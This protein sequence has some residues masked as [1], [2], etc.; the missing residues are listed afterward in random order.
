[1]TTPLRILAHDSGDG[2]IIRHCPFCGGGQVI[3]RSDGTIECEYCPQAFTVQVQPLYSGFPQ[4]VNGMPFPIPGM[5]GQIGGPPAAA[6]P[7][8][9]AG[10]DDTG[11]NPFADDAGDDP[12]AG[13]DA[14]PWADDSSDAGDPGDDAPPPPP[15]KDKG[16]K[17]SS[18]RAVYRTAAGG[19][20]SADAYTE[21][22]AV[23]HA[24]DEEREALL[25]RLR[26]SRY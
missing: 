14:P 4:S 17:K 9:P 1:M 20:L 25:E 23:R 10:L 16:K 22:L 21:Y 2:A 3:G 13:D 19:A 6:G 11:G 18:A 7:T 8:G 5:P 12:D 15:A 24:R 26:T